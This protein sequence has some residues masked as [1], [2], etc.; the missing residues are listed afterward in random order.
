MAEVSCISFSELLELQYFAK[1]KQIEAIKAK[2]ITL[3]F[4]VGTLLLDRSPPYLGTETLR[5]SLLYL[6]FEHL[7]NFKRQTDS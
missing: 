6:S 4:Q 7:S 1:L 2:P 5:H 3:P